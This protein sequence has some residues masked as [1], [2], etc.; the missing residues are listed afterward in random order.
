MNL[1]TDITALMLLPGCQQQHPACQYLS[2]H[3]YTKVFP[4]K[5]ARDMA[6]QMVISE[7]QHG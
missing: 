1:F 2:L 3:Q 5:A 6:Q 7:K 4:S